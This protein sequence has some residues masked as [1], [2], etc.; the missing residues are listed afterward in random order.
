MARATTESERLVNAYVGAWNE[1]DYSTVPELVSES[2]V[3]RNPTAPG[4]VVRG[5]DELEAFMR[6]TVAGFPD[7]HVSVLEMLAGDDRVMYEAELTMTHEGEFD[8]IPPTGREIEIREMAVCE[9]A[10]GEIREYRTYFD[11]Q[12]VLE[13]LGLAE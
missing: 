12:E 8:E 4:G 2:I 9:I 5:H 7:F 13:Q 1:R 3:V 11:Q 6:G 10:D